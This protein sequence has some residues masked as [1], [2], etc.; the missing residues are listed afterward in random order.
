[1]KNLFH[2]LRKFVA[3]LV[4]PKKEASLAIATR[5]QKAFRQTTI[6]PRVGSVMRSHLPLPLLREKIASRDFWYH[7]IEFAPNVIAPG[8]ND[9]RR[10]LQYLRLPENLTGRRVLDIGAAEGYF[11]FECEGRGAS[12]L[13]AID[14]SSPEHT[15]FSMCAKL[16]SSKA[17][18]VL[19]TVYNLTSE[20]FGRFDVVL[21]LGILYHLPDPLLALHI[22]RDLCKSDALVFIETQITDGV[23]IRPDGV[24]L[25]LDSK[26]QSA[27]Q[28]I[29]MMQF[30]VG[31]SL[32]PDD[33]TNFWGPNVACVYAMLKDAGFEVLDYSVFMPQRA[34]FNCRAVAPSE[35]GHLIRQA[36]GSLLRR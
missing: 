34:V 12:E 33:F 4:S 27:L 24:Q 29:P 32:N 22:I 3:K 23:V 2:L 21:F 11:T 15:G 31:N 18:H 17:H 19:D 30:Y 20:R 25:S 9:C 1:M 8:M 36:Y 7:Q 14:Y 6:T 35:R 13:I 10:T 26:T 5:D 28:Q 16:F